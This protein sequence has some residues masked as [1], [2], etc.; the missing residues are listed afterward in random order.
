MYGSRAREPLMP[1]AGVVP[2][3]VPASLP[4]LTLPSL[5]KLRSP[6]RSITGSAE[7]SA[8]IPLGSKPSS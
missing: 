3:S 4:V 8:G 6:G 2:P 7:T 1:A 5:T